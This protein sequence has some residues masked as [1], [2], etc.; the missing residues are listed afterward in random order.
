MRCAVLACL[1]KAPKALGISNE[2]QMKRLGI[3]ALHHT[4]PILQVSALLD[5]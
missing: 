1:L 5:M 2:D 4:P 3:L